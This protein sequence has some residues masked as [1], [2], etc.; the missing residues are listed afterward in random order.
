MSVAVIAAEHAL[1]LTA[2][3]NKVFYVLKENER[4][5]FPYS[6]TAKIACS[7]QA[8]YYNPENKNTSSV[9]LKV[10]NSK[11]EICAD[12]IVKLTKT[13]TPIDAEISLYAYFNVDKN[14]TYY[15]SL[16]KTGYDTILSNL[17]TANIYAT[18][19]YGNKLVETI[20]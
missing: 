8:Q 5:K 3:E 16:S 19:V 18:T 7:G 10:F 13:G 20:K 4:V 6:G 12:Y 9:T 17:D 2:D 15:F 11:G 1:R 14:E